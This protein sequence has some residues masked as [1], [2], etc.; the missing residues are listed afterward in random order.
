MM[1]WNDEENPDR[2]Q[3]PDD[4]LD[5]L[6]GI[7]CKRIPVDHAHALATALR[8]AVPWVAQERGVAVHAIHVAGSQ[9]GW[10][11]P[12]HGT[13][14]YLLVSRR[15]K[16]TLRAPR[17][18]VE[19]LLQDLPGTRLDVGGESLVVGEGKAK[20]LS[21]ETTLFARYVAL[22]L[23]ESAHD[24]GAFL[25]AAARSLTDMGIRIRKALCG[26]TN[27]LATPN[28]AILTRSLMLA[29]LTPDESIRLQ[30]QGLG[31]HPLMGCGIFIPH[32]GIDSLNP[33]EN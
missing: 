15:T 5:L 3:V 33:G 31:R 23:A 9:N 29:G 26:K 25:D 21:K 4:I 12:E 10:E 14:S 19:E 20:P 27:L 32:K 8:E 16:L 1:F 6:F 13:D 7:Q 11:R 17:H 22:D 2:I 28:G 30:Q 18:R 24:E